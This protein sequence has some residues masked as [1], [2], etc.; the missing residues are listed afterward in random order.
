MGGQIIFQDGHVGFAEKLSKTLEEGRFAHNHLLHFRQADGLEQAGEIK[1]RI[2]GIELFRRQGIVLRLYVALLLPGPGNL[3]QEV[4]HDQGIGGDSRA[5]GHTGQAQDP[6]QVGTVTR[7]DGGVFFFQV[8]VPVSD[9]Q[10]ALGQI[11]DLGIAVHQVSHDITAEEHILAILEKIAHLLHQGGLVVERGNLGQ[12][13]LDRSGAG[14][15][16]DGGIEG[17]LIQVHNLLLYRSRNGFHL[18][19]ALEQVVQADPVVFGQH[20]EGAETGIFRFQR[21]FLLPATIYIMIK[22]LFRGNTQIKVARIDSRDFRSAASRQGQG[23]THNHQNFFH[24]KL[25]KLTR[26]FSIPV[27]FCPRDWPAVTLSPWL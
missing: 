17:H 3:G 14:L 1:A 26:E 19:H 21:V 15:V 6:L 7:L 10:S 22:I 8:I 5:V 9:A 18:G 23:R 11:Q 13:W 25:N 12:Q 24:K 4:F 27:F 2:S 20:V 16:A